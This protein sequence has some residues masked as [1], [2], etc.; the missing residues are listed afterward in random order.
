[1]N[2]RTYAPL[3]R[4]RASLAGILRILLSVEDLRKAR[5]F[6]PPFSDEFFYM[7]TLSNLPVDFKINFTYTNVRFLDN[8][9]CLDKLNIT[10]T[11][12]F[13]GAIIN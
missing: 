3:F 8:S 7:F 10:F 5:T 11:N 1:M 12:V 4:P 6:T 9:A 2:N 13:L